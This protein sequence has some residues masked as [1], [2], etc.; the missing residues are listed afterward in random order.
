TNGGKIASNGGTFTVNGQVGGAGSISH[1]TL[2]N[3]VLNGNNV[4]NGLG[5]NAGTVTLGT[6]TAAGVGEITIN[7]NATLAAGVNGLAIAN[8]LE[9]TARAIIDS[10]AF[11][12]TL[13]GEIGG[14]GSLTKVGSGT[15]FL[16]RN[17][18]YQGGTFING[19]A[20]SI[21][22][23]G[24]LGS[25]P[26]SF[27][28]GSLIF[29]PGLNFGGNIVLIGNGLFDTAGAN[30]ILSGIISGAGSLTKAG[31]GSLTLTNVNTY[32][33]GTIITG[34][35]LIG[36]SLSFGT[37]N[38]LNN[39]NL[40]F[41]QTVDGTYARVISGSGTVT[42]IGGARLELSGISTYTGATA[43]NVGELRVS[44]S[45]AA[46]TVT[47]ASGATL[48]GAGTVGGLVAQ[49]GATVA[50]GNG[51][52][53]TLSVAGPVTFQAGSTYAAQ[54]TPAA[55]DRITATGAASLAGTLALSVAPGTYTFGTG[56]TVLSAS[57]LTGTFSSV[58]GLGGFGTGFNPMVSYAGNMVRVALAP[59]SLAAAGG[60]GLRG[61]ALEVARAFDRAI[62]AGYNP[63][64]F[65]DLFTQGANLPTAL[66]QL[67]G[68]IHSAERRVAMED[69]RVVRDT[70]FDRL[71]AGLAALSGTQAATTTNGDAE[72]TFWFRGV[73]S[74]G[75]AQGDAIG[76]RF[77]TEQI[78]VLTGVDYAKDG[79]KVGAGFTYT[80]NDIEFASL[81]TARVKSTGGVAYAGYRD[82]SGFAVGVGGSVAGTRSSSNRAITATG[83]GQSLRGT[84]DGTTYQ[85]FG[86]LSYNIAAGPTTQITPFARYA[87]V[88]T[89]ANAFGE[90]GGI[91]AVNGVRQSYD[92]SVVQAGL[93]A[94]FDLGGGTSL[95]GSA[96]WQSITGDRAPIANLSI[97]GLGQTMPISA[98]ALDKNSAALEAKVNFRIGNNAGVS[99]GYNGVIGDRNTDHGARGTFTLGF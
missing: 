69:T 25:G 30:S 3:L 41:N 51:A 9:L 89:K 67:S 33:G 81:G 99:V 95:A 78:G 62:A 83:L 31:L 88:N 93:R 35:S 36:N 54:I 40:T 91:A 71:N 85:L 18:V 87:Y 50:P 66:S 75:V 28:G 27:N 49:S 47:I 80:Q 68:E 42:K 97:T 72:T 37:G 15:L 90:T 56:Y 5:I 32:A 11:N 61:N 98:A 16:T 53:G 57:A 21:A 2:G 94:G 86:E 34:G 38:I 26:V 17:N 14:A 19:G 1:V 22:T 58:T 13:N 55:A 96:A 92:I 70:A 4:F 8:R 20:I 76:S 73:G 44:G 64:P 52:I 46:S 43:V 65:F 74:W 84:V 59:A 77:T 24:A 23:A 63:Q 6:N 60:A 45:I 7:D 10:G 39:A 48:S 82:P 29:G 12:F 79:F